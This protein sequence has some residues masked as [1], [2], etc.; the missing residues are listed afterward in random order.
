VLL[1]T[2]LGALLVWATAEEDE[3]TL[4]VVKTLLEAEEASEVRTAAT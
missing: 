2:L 4:D 1:A 3:E